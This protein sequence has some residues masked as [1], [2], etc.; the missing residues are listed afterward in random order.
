VP[1]TS[2]LEANISYD[3]NTI[4]WQRRLHWDGQVRRVDDNYLPK[5]VLY[6]DYLRSSV[7]WTPKLLRFKDV[8]KRDLAAYG[9]AV[10]VREKWF[11]NKKQSSRKG[12]THRS[13][14]LFG[15][16]RASPCSLL[17]LKDWP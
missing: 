11:S 17:F 13:K 3:L 16:M 14:T 12:E 15:R 1:I 10:E 8:L 6:R 5:N 9:I 2:V 7:V 4:L